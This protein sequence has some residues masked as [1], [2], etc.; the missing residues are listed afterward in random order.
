MFGD[1]ISDLA[2]WGD[3]VYQ[4]TFD[5]FRII[6][7]DDVRDPTVLIDYDQCAN[8]NGAGQGDVVVWGSIL[9]RTWDSNTSAAGVDL[10]RRAGA[11]RPVRR[12]LR[13]P[14]ASRACT[15]STSAIPGTRT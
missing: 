4:G 2:F 7:A 6:D 14:A 15:S 3:T 10:R 8:A 9:V 5:G 12:S 13:A 1:F 11:G